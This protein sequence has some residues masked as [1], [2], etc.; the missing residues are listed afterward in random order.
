MALAASSKRKRSRWRLT[1]CRRGGEPREDPAVGQREVRPG[2]RLRDAPSLELAEREAGRV[3]ELRREVARAG[4]PAAARRRPSSPEAAA[5]ASVN[6]TRVGAELLDRL[7]RVDHVAAGLGHLLAAHADEPVEVHG[8]ERRALGEAQAR[9]D[10][11]RH[12]EEE[13]VVSGDEDVGRIELLRGRGVFLGQPKTEK[14]Q[15][16][17][18]NQ[19]SSTSG[20]CSSGAEPQVAHDVRDLLGDGHVPVARR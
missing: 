8:R 9:H 4:H 15:S 11:P 3:P 16:W 6:R 17:E 20:S 18:E 12:P 14:G 13:D 2:E 10:H 7:E 1:S 5:R 19:V